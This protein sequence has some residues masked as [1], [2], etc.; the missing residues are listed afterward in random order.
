MENI[1]V[2]LGFHTNAIPVKREASWL[3]ELTLQV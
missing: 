2:D 3:I 1:P